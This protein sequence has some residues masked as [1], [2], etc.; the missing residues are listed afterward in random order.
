MAVYTKKSYSKLDRVRRQNSLLRKFA[1]R[2]DLVGIGLNWGEIPKGPGEQTTVG[3]FWNIQF[4][5]SLAFALSLQ[6]L[7]NPALNPETNETWITSLRAR[8]TF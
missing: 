1:Y 4:A 7:G 3:A 6:Y 5:Q 8:L 2:S